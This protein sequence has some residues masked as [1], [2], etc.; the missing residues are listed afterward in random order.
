MISDGL[1]MDTG[2]LYY[3]D[4]PTWLKINIL[5]YMSNLVQGL[6]LPQQ[7][8]TMPYGNDV[9]PFRGLP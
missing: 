8:A 2:Y 9:A 5:V 1:V 4:S 7:G 3:K 6:V